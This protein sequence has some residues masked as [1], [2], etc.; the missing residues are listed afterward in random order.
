MMEQLGKP[1]GVPGVGIPG[2]DVSPMEGLGLASLIAESGYV[3]TK[4]V[5]ADYKPPTPTKESILQGVE[6]ARQLHSLR[7]QWII[8][9]RRL[10]QLANN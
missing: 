8:A 6:H 7:D 10:T 2:S 4:P 1:I 5:P 3:Y 9:G